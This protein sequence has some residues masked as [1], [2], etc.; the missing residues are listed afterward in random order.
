MRRELLGLS[1]DG[2]AGFVGELQEVEPAVAVEGAGGPAAEVLGD[3][4]SAVGFAGLV[5]A[6]LD[7][8][9]HAVV[10]DGRRFP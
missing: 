10:G 7:A 4:G 5:I 8:F 1:L 3:G 6:V 9:D 2:D